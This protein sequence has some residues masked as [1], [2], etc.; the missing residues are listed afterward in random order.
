MEISKYDP[1]SIDSINLNVKGARKY[2]SVKTLLFSILIVSFVFLL[3]WN[4]I[5]N[6]YAGKADL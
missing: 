4:F 2:I 5:S 6:I 1:F 3:N